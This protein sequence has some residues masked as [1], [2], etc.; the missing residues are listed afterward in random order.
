MLLLLDLLS[1]A[2]V[3]RTTGKRQG[4]ILEFIV[5]TVKLDPVNEF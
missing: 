3:R 5:L 2:A 1:V 4:F